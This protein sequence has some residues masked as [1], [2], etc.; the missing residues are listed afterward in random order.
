LPE[1]QVVKALSL[2]LDHLKFHRTEKPFIA[3]FGK[4]EDKIKPL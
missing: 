2:L 4:L 1:L 3:S